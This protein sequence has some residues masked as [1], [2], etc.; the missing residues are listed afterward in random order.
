LIAKY[1]NDLPAWAF[2]EIIPFGRFISFYQHC[3][4]HLSNEKMA[5]EFYLLIAIKELRNAT[6]HSNCIINDLHPKTS[7][8][9]TNHSVLR[10]LD[11]IDTSRH[12]RQKKM[13]NTRIQQ[14]V[15]LMY[16]HKLLVT[17]EGVHDHQSIVLEELTTRMFKNIDYYTKIPMI[18]TTFGFLKVVVDKW[19]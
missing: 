19:F 6:A 11:Q 18:S 12:I 7:K 5:D 14:I 1:H 9:K 15:T 17:S 4:K 13:S 10:E 3:A 16:T 2:I 8:R